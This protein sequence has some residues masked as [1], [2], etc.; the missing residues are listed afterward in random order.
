MFSKFHSKNALKINV[1]DSS[2]YNKSLNIFLQLSQITDVTKQ[3]FCSI[4]H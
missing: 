3:L 4:T 2:N 1:L